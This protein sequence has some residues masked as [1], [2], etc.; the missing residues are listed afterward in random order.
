MILVT[1]ASGFLGSHLLQALVHQGAT[2]R[3]LYHTRKP[4]FEHPKV[5]WL[6]CDLLDVYAVEDAM[7]GIS[8][9]YHCAAIVSFDKKDRERVIE[10]NRASTANVVDEALNAKVEKLIHVSSIASLGRAI[11]EG[12]LVSEETHWE[13]SPNNTAYSIGKYQSELEV[14]RGMAEGLNAAIVNPGIILGEGDYEL[15]SSKLFKTVYEELNW[16]T[17]GI[18]GWVDVQ[19]LLKAMIALMNSDIR[20]ERF[21]ITADN[22]SYKDIFTWMAESLE[23][24]P[25]QKKASALMSGLIW[26]LSA[27]K[28]SLTGKTSSITRETART[29]QTKV[30]YDNSKLLKFLPKFSYTSIKKTIARVAQDF[31]NKV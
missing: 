17:E 25:P 14:W 6:N 15:G 30:F 23:K 28:S 5:E 2:V 4:T 27:L 8:Q 13:D 18:N 9:V 19:D 21:I 22:F 16:F 29:A 20:N 12:T 7:V 26:R 3:A 11:K 1:G 31:L 10:Q 24:R